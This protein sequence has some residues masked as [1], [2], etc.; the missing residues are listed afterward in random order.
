M[1]DENKYKNTS[2]RKKEALISY[3]T[4]RSYSNSARQIWSQHIREDEQFRHN[5]QWAKSQ[6]DTLADRGQSAVAIN[7]IDA[8]IQA[9]IAIMTARRPSWVAVP[10]EDTDV[11]I[12]KVAE[13]MLEHMYD[14]SNGAL[15]LANAVDDFLTK[16]EAV[17]LVYYDPI[18]YNGKG[19]VKFIDIDPLE[20][21]VD[22][23][24]KRRDLEDA[25]HILI[26]RNITRKQAIKLWPHLK[27]KIL[28]ASASDESIYPT[29]DKDAIEGQTFPGE[30]DYAEKEKLKVIERYTKKQV[31]L[32]HVFET[33]SGSEYAYT[34]EELDAYLSKQ[35]Y[36]VGNQ[37][38]DYDD[39]TGLMAA[40][41]D[42][43]LDDIDQILVTSGNELVETEQI[44]VRP[45]M[46]MRVHRYLS[47]E[48]ELLEEEQMSTDEYPVKVAMNKWNRTPYPESD[49]RYAKGIQ[50][51][52]NKINS[53]IIAHA[54]AATNIKLLIPEGSMDQK[55][56]AQEW[57]KPNAVLTFNPEFGTPF[58]PQHPSLPAELYQ[59]QSIW[60]QDIRYQF[61]VPEL[62]HGFTENSPETYR[63]TMIMEEF[64]QRKIKSK[65]RLI[66]NALEGVARVAFKMMQSYYTEE[67]IFRVVQPSGSVSEVRINYMGVD[68]FSGEIAKFNDIS[69]GE[70]DF[71]FV[72]GST[73]PS[74]RWAEF[75]YYMQLYQAKAID[76]I[77]LLKKSELVDVEGVLSRF[78]YIKQMETMV[79]QLQEEVKRLRGDLQTAERES[80]HDRKRLEVEK[81]KSDLDEVKTKAVASSM[82]F[83]A[84]L[85][86]TLSN[87]KGSTKE[88]SGGTEK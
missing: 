52:I 25:E 72:G 12:A 60:K 47:V 45:V 67:D 2:V 23:N 70:Y 69:I 84:R 55:K 77:E 27:N 49:V 4:F 44:V 71:K 16:S 81:F 43:S 6:V 54:T 36:V 3:D 68:E 56:V 34:Q 65:M 63:G 62:M 73:L 5:V 61:G 53:L 80:L 37:V 59:T 33:F 79:Q 39:Q 57:A 86:D 30:I 88:K 66:E 42:M 19:R 35:Y 75:D 48:E 85:N 13:R 83:D 41:S 74:N 38:F 50:Q 31:K 1:E 18:A 21:Y 82:L 29:T 32:Y 20:L 14:I 22:P 24:C 28:S 10:R 76:Q 9:T 64:G 15:V 40:L 8:A 11:K 87:I 51:Y 17:F 7:Q 58:V 46:A 78:N 26:V